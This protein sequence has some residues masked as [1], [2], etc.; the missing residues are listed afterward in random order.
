[1]KLLH[2]LPKMSELLSHDA[3]LLK[4]IRIAVPAF[5]FISAITVFWGVKAH[6]S[7]YLSYYPAWVQYPAFSLG[8]LLFS[9]APDALNAILVAYVA[10]TI[11]KRKFD[12][13]S[14]ILIVFCAGLSGGLTFYS[15]QMSKFSAVEAANEASGEAETIDLTPIDAKHDA[16]L[17]RIQDDYNAEK[18]TIEGNYAALIETENQ[19]I[20]SWEKKRNDGNTQWIDRQQDKRRKIIATLLEK[21]KSDLE[22]LRNRKQAI[23]DKANAQHEKD[24]TKAESDNKAK[25][26]KHESFAAIFADKLSWLSGNAVFVVLILTCIREILYNR[27]GVEIKPIFG[28][29]DFQPSSILETLALP[30]TAVGRHII[31]RVRAAYEALPE[32]KRRPDFPAVIDYSGYEQRID[33]FDYETAREKQTQG[34]SQSKTTPSAKQS[35]QP[36]DRD[37]R[38][39]KK[40][41]TGITVAKCLDNYEYW[42]GQ[43]QSE[44]EVKK[45][46]KFWR[47]KVLAFTG[48]QPEDVKGVSAP[49]DDFWK[50]LMHDIDMNELFEDN[51]FSKNVATTTQTAAVEVEP[52]TSA[53]KIFTNGQR[54]TIRGFQPYRF[55]PFNENRLNENRNNDA[56]KVVEGTRVCAHCDT[57]YHHRHHKQKYCSEDCRIVAWEQRTGRKFTKPDTKRKRK[58]KS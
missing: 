5:I 44:P 58:T 25:E 28:Q 52:D 53:S 2:S 49:D 55:E 57:V 32:L 34:S 51:G 9:L 24:R 43:D 31:N 14:M 54:I 37:Y 16:A 46:V 7:G 3:P 23:E 36:D 42:K 40:F 29:F 47:N 27:N 38:N 41:A 33:Y 50:D 11:L 30:F 10:R 21:Q 35:A 19:A 12:H 26:T 20:A 13:L 6:I 8:F 1:M 48:Q 45:Q 56:Q 15:Y 18:Q 17:Q 4:I 39:F 22:A